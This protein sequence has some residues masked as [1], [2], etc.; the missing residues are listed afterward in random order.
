[1]ACC[2][3]AAYFKSFVGTVIL[4]VEN[5]WP[6]SGDHLAKKERIA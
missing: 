6:S 1:M 3:L 4:V 5:G 2:L